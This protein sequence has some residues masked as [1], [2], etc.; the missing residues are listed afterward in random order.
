MSSIEAGIHARAGQA[1]DRLW[2]K[3]DITPT[4]RLK[5]SAA[6]PYIEPRYPAVLAIKKIVADY[7]SVTCVDIE[8]CRIGRGIAR[9]RHVAIY[10]TRLLTLHG[11]PEI[12]RR[13]GGR[14]HSTIYA[15]TSNM[16]ETVKAGK[17]LKLL[18]EIDELKTIIVGQ[19]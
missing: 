13:F 17:D 11:L 9:P 12:G 4:M 16:E 1:K 6:D 15:C 7:Y 19:T 8:S 14:D 5:A 3:R 2:S 10:L 18:T